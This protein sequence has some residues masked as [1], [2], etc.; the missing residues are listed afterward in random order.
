MHVPFGRY[1]LS[2]LF[3]FHPSG[4]CLKTLLSGLCNTRSKWRYQLSWVYLSH[5]DQADSWGFWLYNLSGNMRVSQA[6]G[7]LF[8]EI[9]M[10]FQF[11]S[12][13]WLAIEGPEACKVESLNTRNLGC[14]DN[15][16]FRV[17]LGLTF[18]P[19]KFHQQ[20]CWIDFSEAVLLRMWRSRSKD[21]PFLSI[22][23]QQI[24]RSWQNL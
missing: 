2:L 17:D 6:P 8:R 4:E 16:A 7:G 1:T 23:L 22:R 24:S 11:C 3:H 21:K 14:Q 19:A 12:L 5:P 15:V 9:F 13:L 10:Q 20:A 18:S